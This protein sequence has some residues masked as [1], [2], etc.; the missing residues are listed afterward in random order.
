MHLPRVAMLLDDPDLPDG[1]TDAQV[2]GRGLV[3]GVAGPRP[4]GV[5]RASTVPRSRSSLS[6]RSLR[7][8][9]LG[10]AWRPP[11]PATSMAHGPHAGLCF[12]APGRP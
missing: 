10:E 9:V 4:E 11:T 1:P 2:P 7:R 8:I 5:G 6:G 12:R 3:G